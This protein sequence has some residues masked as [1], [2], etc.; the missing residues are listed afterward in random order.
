VRIARY[1]LVKRSA[2]WDADRF[3]GWSFPGLRYR[4]PWCQGDTHFW[5]DWP[6]LHPMARLARV[7]RLAPDGKTGTSGQTCTKWVALRPGSFAHTHPD[8]PR[9]L[10]RPGRAQE[11]TETVP[12]WTS[13][14]RL[15]GVRAATGRLHA[16]ADALPFSV[17]PQTR[18]MER[19]E[20]SE[21][22]GTNR[23]A[24]ALRRKINRECPEWRSESS[25]TRILPES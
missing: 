14:P 3:H 15:P 8:N 17:L 1:G 7:A 13:L 12:G 16:G 6:D 11:G 20:R 21:T 23:A 2:S 9:R 10:G 4:V 18:D 22:H 24:G 5:P 25:P 19:M